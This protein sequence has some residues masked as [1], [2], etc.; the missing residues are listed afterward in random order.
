MMKHFLKTGIILLLIIFKSALLQAQNQ[1]LDSLNRLIRTETDPKARIKHMME[2]ADL[3]AIINLDSAISFNLKIVA[4]SKKIKYGLGQEEAMLKLVHNY[5]FTGNFRAALQQ[6]D[7]L[8]RYVEQKQDSGSFANYYSVAGLFYG[9]QSKYD[10][11]IYFYEKAIPLY[12]KIGNRE[13]TG[14]S[15][16][17]LAI[18]YQQQ[19]NYPKTL[20]YQQK[21][22]KIQEEDGDISGQAYTLVN[23][24]NTYQNMGDNIR[25]EK[26]FLKSIELAQKKQLTNVELYAFTNLSSMFLEMEQW[27]KAYDYGMQAAELGG[28]MGDKGIQAASLSKAALAKARQYKPDEALVLSKRAI[29]LADSVNQPMIIQQAYSGM[30][31]VLK[32]QK[33]WKEAIP[34]YEKALAA[35]KDVDLFIEENGSLF[36]ELSECYEQTGN[37]AKALEMYKKFMVIAD[38]VHSR[39]NIQKATELTM[40]YEFEKREQA[41]KVKQDAKDE[42]NRTRL[43]GLLSGLGLSLI[44]IIGALIGYRGK[45]RAN[46]QLRQQKN[47]IE[48]A[49]E[50]LKDTQ[51]QLIQSEKMASLGELTAGIAHEIQNPLN[52]VNNFSEV[53]K[54]LFGEMNDELAVGNWQLAKEISKDIE[55]NLEKINHHGKRADAIVKGMLQHSRSSSGVK[56]PSDINALADEYLRL[57]YHG[58]RAKD[59]SFNARFETDLDASMPLVD[60][61]PQDIGRVILNLLTNAFYAVN[62]KKQQQSVDS[63]YE[64]IVSISTKKTGD[65]VE[66]EVTDNG[67]GIPQKVLDKI[68][69]PFFTTKPTGQG[70][71]LGLSLSYDIITKGH[72]GTLKVETREGEA[73]SFII[74]I[75]A[76]PA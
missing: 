2:K 14:Q 61:V 59:K 58:L 65:T 43:I 51:S 53:S 57:C 15:A 64:P 41:E 73:T 5:T 11:S 39:D 36:K 56:E 49:L 69:Q 37:P 33:K 35:L 48:D 28:K 34:Y 54:E 29:V 12:E 66:I 38:S 16:S 42:L 32:S 67:N 4:E 3:L 47:E 46:A 75:P 70:T 23:M 20:F 21:A 55:Q 8:R 76:L 45:Q 9:M 1:K 13:R 71:G 72:E 44:I 6:L 24:A 60:V 22:L 68:F 26:T 50:K 63:G 10:S 62:E 52:F 74:Q 19:S 25:A 40:N 30:G 7:N 27:Q 31:F 18:G 17:N